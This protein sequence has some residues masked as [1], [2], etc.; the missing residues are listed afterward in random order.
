MSKYTPYHYNG[1][2]ML[3]DTYLVL[4]EEYCDPESY[5][6]FEMNI[7]GTAC[8]KINEVEKNGYEKF[9]I[10][11]EVNS[12]GFNSF[13]YCENLKNKKIF[14]YSEVY[15]ETKTKI[16]VNVTCPRN[17]K[18]WVNHKCL[19][20]HNYGQGYYLTVYLNKGKNTFLV[21]QYSP[22]IMSI[23]TIQLRNYKFEMSDDFK[24]L[25]NCIDMSQ[26]NPLT[27]ISENCNQLSD[28]R[29]K[30]MYMINDEKIY[31]PDYLIEIIDSING[32]VK[33]MNA[34]INEVIEID[35]DELRGLHEEKLRHDFIGC[36]FWDNNGNK[37]VTGPNLFVNDF[38]DRQLEINKKLEY[39]GNKLGQEIADNIQGR[40]CCQ[41]NLNNEDLYWEILRNKDMISQLETGNYPHDFYKYTGIHSFFIYSKLDD[42]YIRIA[43]RVPRD[44]DKSKRYPVII[45]LATGNDGCFSCSLPEDK[46]SEPVLCFDVTGRG[47][48][49]GSY[50]GEAST[51]EV[52]DWIK[53]NYTI[54]EDRVYI[55]GGSNGGFATWATAQNRPN[56]AA[57]IYPHT[58]YPY[59]PNIENTKDIPTFQLVSPND[60]VFKGKENEVKNKLKKYGNY[61]QYDFNEML[62]YHMGLYITHPT[63]LNEM[64]KTKR[65]MFPNEIIYR[66][67]RNRNLESYW[68]KLHG[69]RKEKKFAKIR[70]TIENNELIN[71]NIQNADG[72]TITIPPRINKKRFVISINNKN[73]EFKA[74]TQE[75]LHFTYRK[76]WRCMENEPTDIDYRKGTGL[77]DIYMNS[78]RI[79]VPNDASDNIMKT[80]KN[81][82]RPYSNGYYTVV[83]TNYPIY[84]ENEEPSHTFS[85][86]LILFDVNGNN[87]Y[88]K[89]FED[90]LLVKCDERGYEYK[91]SR[92]DCDY[93]V[94]QIIPNPYYPKLSM[95]II[96]TNNENLL[97]KHILL[98]KVI[99]PTYVNGIHDYWNNEVLI[100]VDGKYYRAY[101]ADG[102]LDLIKNIRS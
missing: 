28:S 43:V 62:H 33:T 40:I 50:V 84:K 42:S 90:K 53:K 79:M 38:K 41:K 65:N 57:A 32:L 30:F 34:K 67:E 70:A 36:S 97:Q 94:M 73:F 63:I 45:A 72:F 83:H 52:L 47:F 61:H 95:L 86:N 92:Q 55:L 99:I 49:G 69:I 15:S 37:I 91:G 78:M 59:I 13:K 48:T 46:L 100:Y 68:I 39:Y 22:D 27:L 44:Y 76:I 11:S 12:E 101:E 10:W 31:K 77:L 35:L 25:S 4:Y 98:R 8:A 14:L 71:V 85:N 89:R 88:V 21:E 29:Y 16:I 2:T 58:G 60:Y 74:C 87:S 6:I 18:L 54:D 102:D 93:V 3:I 7:N 1:K 17:G 19:S 64:I 5:N 81:F 80:A 51:F 96:S 66:T 20:I 24:A 56:L 26:L 75:Q 9:R 23:L 82:S